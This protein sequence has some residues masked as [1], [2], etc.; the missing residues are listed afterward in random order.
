MIASLLGF[1]L[2]EAPKGGVGLDVFAEEP[3]L[4][5]SAFL[6][7]GSAF[8]GLEGAATGV[9]DFSPVMDASSWPICESA[10]ANVRIVNQENLMTRVTSHVTGK[11]EK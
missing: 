8:E 5:S 7:I 3:L 9:P 11:R 1:A 2:P 4:S 6:L 10:K